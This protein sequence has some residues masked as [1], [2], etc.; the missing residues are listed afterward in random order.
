MK[1]EYCAINDNLDKGKKFLKF[2]AEGTP[3]EIGN[4]HQTMVELG[5]DDWELVTLTQINEPNARVYYF[6]RPSSN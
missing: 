3:K 5:Q 6:K 4:V 2:F 1:W